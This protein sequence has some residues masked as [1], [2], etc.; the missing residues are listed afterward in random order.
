M[1][2][3]YD[4]I[5][6]DV[7]VRDTAS[8]R[9]AL[10]ISDAFLVPCAPRSLDIWTIHKVLDIVEE[11]EVINPSLKFLA[12]YLGNRKSFSNASS[13]GLSILELSPPDKKAISEF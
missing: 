12:S 3:K 7:G 6:I 2:S 1:K 5:I 10:T 9:A 13:V 4:I 8:Q 11:I